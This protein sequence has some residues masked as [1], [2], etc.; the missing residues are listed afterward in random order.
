MDCLKFFKELH[1]ILGKAI[2]EH[3][4]KPRYEMP[5]DRE[6][7]DALDALTI[8]PLVAVAA[9]G[10][11]TVLMTSDEFDQLRKDATE[12]MDTSGMAFAEIGGE[13]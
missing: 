9:E 13:A 10:E 3:D 7:M 6:V 1:S 4:P 8:R 12:Y 11:P 5:I 2:A